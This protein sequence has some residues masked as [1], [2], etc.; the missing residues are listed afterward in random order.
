MNFIYHSLTL[1][2]YIYNVFQ[3]QGVKMPFMQRCGV[4]IVFVF[5][6]YVVARAIID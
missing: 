5:V 3:I 2:T 4:A 1:F 6:V